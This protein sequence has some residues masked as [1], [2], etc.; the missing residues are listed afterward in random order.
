MWRVCPFWQGFGFIWRTLKLLVTQHCPGKQPLATQTLT[1]GQEESWAER[2]QT[3]VMTTSCCPIHTHGH[4]HAHIQTHTHTLFSSLKIQKAA[5]LKDI[6]KCHQTSANRLNETG[7]MWIPPSRCSHLHTFVCI[8]RTVPLSLIRGLTSFLN[9][10]SQSCTGDFPGS[11]LTLGEV[12]SLS[13]GQYDLLW[14]CHSVKKSV[15]RVHSFIYWPHYSFRK[16]M[17]TLTI[18]KVI[19]YLLLGEMITLTHQCSCRDWDSLQQ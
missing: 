12:T 7:F 8:H 13:M 2:R 4:A 9:E 1:K 3:W 10:H 19:L 14:A 6:C 16:D 5:L 11:Y 15:L 18:V 17:P